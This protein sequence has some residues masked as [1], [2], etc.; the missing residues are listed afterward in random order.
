MIDPTG[1]DVGFSE[2][3]ALCP[4]SLTQ[5]TPKELLPW[6]GRLGSGFGGG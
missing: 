2:L 5:M 4:M 1:N 3:I 6:F